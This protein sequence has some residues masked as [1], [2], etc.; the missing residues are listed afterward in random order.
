MYQADCRHINSYIDFI[1][2]FNKTIIEPVGGKWNGNLDA[3][4]DY[5]SWPKPNPYHLVI[6][7]SEHCAEIL[8]YKESERHEKKLWPLLR[9]ILQENGRWVLVDF[10]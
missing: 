5:L 7:G 8:N 3:F 4:N 2:V 6:L 10:K 1:E 9:E